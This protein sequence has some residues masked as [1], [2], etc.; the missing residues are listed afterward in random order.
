MSRIGVLGG[1][2]FLAN[3][4]I[5]RKVKI[6]MTGETET[7][8][9]LIKTSLETFPGRDDR[10]R[11]VVLRKIDFSRAEIECVGRQGQDMDFCSEV[12]SIVENSTIESLTENLVRIESK[13]KNHFE[14]VTVV[15]NSDKEKLIER[16]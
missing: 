9:W 13:L 16:T 7:T 12:Y 8:N 6:A 5:G 15:A 4:A 1:V 14:Q 2:I 3:L 11:V 10:H